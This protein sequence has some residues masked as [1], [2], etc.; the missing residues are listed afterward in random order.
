MLNQAL[1][2]IF[3]HPAVELVSHGLAVL[4][5]GG[6]DGKV[7]LV[8]GFNIYRRPPGRAIVE[9]WFAKWPDANI[10]VL[11]GLSKVV[12]VDVDDPA[13]LNRAFEQFGATSLIIQTPR[14]GYQLWYRARGGEKP[15][16][17]R[18]SEGLAIEIKA[19]TSSIVI[20]PP[21]VNPRIGRAYAFHK[22]DWSCLSHLP[23]F[24]EQERGGQ[25]GSPGPAEIGER[26]ERL[27]RLCMRT[28]PTCSSIDELLVEAREWN[29]YH[30][31]PPL[32]DR[33]VEKTVTSAW[34][35]EANGMN[36]VAGPGAVIISHNI[37]TSFTTLPAAVI[38]MR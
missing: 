18:K 26:N 35:Y 20:V 11:T 1:T 27:F 6:E 25:I 13:L 16:N 34:W 32:P 15:R 36:F 28:A 22:G 4:P 38:P 24:A 29:H 10:G 17:L 14:P 2:P 30:C 12:V 8:R 9:K 21:S 7:P 3:L 23:L 33:E 19:G 31:Q 37:R 5:T